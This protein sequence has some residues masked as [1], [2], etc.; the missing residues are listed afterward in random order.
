MAISSIDGTSCLG[1]LRQRLQLVDLPDR[2]VF[3][4]A[5]SG[6]ASCCWLRYRS[7]GV[8]AP[9]LVWG[10]P[11]T[12][13]LPPQCMA[14]CMITRDLDSSFKVQALIHVYTNRWRNLGYHKVNWKSNTC[15]EIIVRNINKTFT[16]GYQYYNYTLRH[17][18][19]IPNRATETNV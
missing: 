19:K 18:T 15:H 16:C 5:H 12:S 4:P 10:T 1:G 17:H 11:S 6:V 9:S 7:A 13:R 14:A 8:P 2:S 3:Q